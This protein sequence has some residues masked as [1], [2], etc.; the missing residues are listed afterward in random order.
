MSELEVDSMSGC[1]NAKLRA[2]A[3]LVQLARRRSRAA[4]ERKRTDTTRRGRSEGSSSFVAS[5][6]AS[7]E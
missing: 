6:R 2:F 3:P 7:R 5:T 4:D 1:D